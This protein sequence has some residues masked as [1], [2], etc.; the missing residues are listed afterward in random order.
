MSVFRPSAHAL[1]TGGASG[2]GY[3]VAR[4]CLSHSMRVTITDTN[5]TL[6]DQAS[7]S[8][9]GNLTSIK[10]DVTSRSD[11]TSLKQRIG[12]DIDF[13]MLNAGIGG[14]GT[15]GDAEYFDSILGTNLGGVVN[16]LNAFV[17]VMLEKEK[18]AEKKAIVITGSKQGI[19]NPPGNAAYNASK[20][21]VKTL[22]EH[23]NFDLKDT[24]VGV[25]L[26]VPGWT[27][28]GLAGKVPGSDT[29]TPEG[30]WSADQVAEYMFEK[31]KDDKFYIIGPDGQVTE[32]T[33]KKCML[34]IVGDIING[35]SPLTRR[36]P[37]YKEEAEKW[38]AEQKV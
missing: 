29:E 10:A 6:L 2:I 15:W 28:T 26:L 21:A 11:W 33:D 14:K 37:E 12:S 8:L 25:H 4:L 36:R 19:T 1:I 17:P 30:A 3:A 18:E 31:M 23:L 24:N 22:A 16:G 32:E 7:K 5:Q 34:W 13:L 9:S 35:R 27:F 20:A 38:M